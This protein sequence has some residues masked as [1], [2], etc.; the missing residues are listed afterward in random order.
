MLYDLIILGAGPAGLA[1]SIYAS[2]H[3]LNHLVIG[4]IIGGTP[5]EAALIKNWPGTEAISGA[6]LMKN[7]RIHAE[8]LGGKIIQGRVAG[9]KKTKDYFEINADGQIYQSKSLLVAFGTRR[10]KMN[11]PGE[12]KFLGKGVSYCATCDAVFFK[13]KTVAVIG[14]GNSAAMAAILLAEHAK[15]VYLVY[16]G[17]KLK[18]LPASLEQLQKNPKITII[19]NTNVLEARGAN[20]VENIVL[21]K[22]FDGNTT[23]KM[24]GVFV[25]IGAMPSTDLL[26]GLGVALND[27]GYVIVDQWGKTNIPG[28]YAA[29]DIITNTPGF[30]QIIAAAA[31]GATAVNAI[32]RHLKEIIRK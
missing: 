15:Q 21:D 19:C 25:E 3:K 18:C 29:G 28:I 4:E 20:K 23:L 16:R 30:N 26:N 17:D 7:F 24:D 2:Y 11:I 22:S 14:G 9:L 6:E 31:D 27:Q 5:L 10:R 8:G 1:A 32:Y 13:N 12:D